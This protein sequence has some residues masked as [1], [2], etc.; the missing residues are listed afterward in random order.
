MVMRL[1]RKLDLLS[2]SLFP[3]LGSASAGGILNSLTT[4][5]H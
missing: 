3:V 1:I 5:V 2:G 4:I